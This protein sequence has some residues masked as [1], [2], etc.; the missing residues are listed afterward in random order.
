MCY[1]PHY[2]H[3]MQHPIRGLHYVT[4]KGPNQETLIRHKQTTSDIST[5][6]RLFIIVHSGDVTSFS[7]SGIEK[8]FRPI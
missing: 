1:L 4:L 5:V 7:F 6:S 2:M 3:L 8:V